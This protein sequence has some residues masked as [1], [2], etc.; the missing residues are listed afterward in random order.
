M[1]SK[2]RTHLQHNVVAYVA[3]FFALTGTAVATHE[4]IRSSDIVD[5]QVRSADVRD[6]TL[7]GGGL[8]AADLAPQAVAGSEVA[9]G[10][11]A[12][13]DID[14]STLFNDNSLATADIDESTLFNDNSLNA[15]DVADNSPLGTAEVNESNLFNDNSLNEVDV[16]NN[17]PLGTA[18]INEGNLYNDNSLGGSDINE[19]DLGKVPDASLLDGIDSSALVIG[20]GEDADSG[21]DECT[22]SLPATSFD[23]CADVTM[24]LPHPGRVHVVG[25]GTF[26]QLAN[27]GQNAHC[28]LQADN[29]NVSPTVTAQAPS[30]SSS[31]KIPL[32]SQAIV[33]LPAGAHSFEFIC[34]SD[35]TPDAADVDGAYISAILLSSG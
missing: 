22:G 27:G 35:V 2:F 20:R 17:S 16:A 26:E 13:E 5:N 23:T 33:S 32:T 3:L 4:S 19:A 15:A 1:F 12:T 18:E 7:A 29:A 25:T 28:L 8:G 11:L 21:E 14:E 6:D 24:T 30:G 9:D 31:S 34:R 10:S